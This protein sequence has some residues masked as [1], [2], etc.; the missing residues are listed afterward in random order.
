MSIEKSQ[1]KSPSR[2][3]SHYYLV[4][5]SFVQ[6]S[7]IPNN[8]KQN[9]FIKLRLT[10]FLFFIIITVVCKLF[11]QDWTDSKL[12]E[13]GVFSWLTYI[14]TVLLAGVI[15]VM[16]EM[17]YKLAVWL[18]DQGTQF[19]CSPSAPTDVK[20]PPLIIYKRVID[21]FISLQQVR[22]TIKL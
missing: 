13:T 1:A 4:C 20:L 6:L 22:I 10:H 9:P 18:N 8:I 7:S 21:N 16:D 12:P 3:I 11:H 2:H 15:T 17:Y 19:K 5:L 14:P